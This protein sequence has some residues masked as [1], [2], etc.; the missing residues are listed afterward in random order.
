MADLICRFPSMPDDRCPSAHGIEFPS[1]VR[2]RA[3]AI[4]GGRLRIR[5]SA[6]LNIFMLELALASLELALGSA[7]TI[8]EQIGERAT[9]EEV[10]R[11]LSTVR[12]LLQ[13]AKART[14]GIAGQDGC[15]VQNEA[16]DSAGAN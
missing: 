2:A 6:R 13:F 9:K 1:P 7:R 15:S 14:S 16:P 11:Y 8:S 4:H 5:E 10:D 3:E 12:E